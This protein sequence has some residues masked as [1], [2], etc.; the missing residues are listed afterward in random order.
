VAKYGPLA[1]IVVALAAIAALASLAEPRATAGAPTTVA[2]GTVSTPITYQQAE[3]SGEVE[4]IEWMA[5]CDPTTGRI[6]EPSVYA[7]PCLPAAPADNGGATSPG[8]TGETITVAVYVPSPNADFL[9][10]FATLLDEPEAVVTTRDAYV[11]LFE[12]TFE[13]YGRGVELVRFE[14]TGAGDDNT[15][16]QADAVTVA[17]TIR[18][19]AVLGGPDRSSAF[20][21]ELAR[22][23]IVCIAC[24]GV[25]P[26]RFYQDHAPYVWGLQP[27]AEQFLVSLGDFLTQ[28]VV[29]RAASFAGDVDLRE[30]ERVFGVVHIEQSPPVFDQVDERTRECGSARGYEAALTETFLLD[31]G[32]MAQRA[33]TIVAKMKAA[34]VTTI[35]FLGDPIMPIHL[36]RAA[37]EQ[38]YHP[39][40]VI[41]G[42]ALTDTTVFGR[43]YDP[44]QWAH[45]F[46]ISSLG[47]RT[48]REQGDPWRLHEWFHGAPPEAVNTH[49]L[50]YAPLRLLFLGIHMAGADLR[51]QTFAQG[52]FNYPESGGGVTSPQISFGDHGYFEL[53]PGEGE[54]CSSAEPRLDYLATDDVTEIWWDAESTGLDEQGNS[55]T[56]MVRYADGGHRYLPGSMTDEELGAFVEEGSITVVDEVPVDQ[57]PPEYPPPARG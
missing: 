28:R 41:T 33:T 14:G 4:G 48:A 31:F 29:G 43:M 22:R 9:N 18:P 34:G 25:V 55:G 35:I 16:A 36:T 27:T 30:R 47:A 50:I 13:T 17:E 11:E 51:P 23:G 7:P 15:A 10:S 52:L 2:P 39:E 6:R 49:A 3:A 19:F 40:W 53:D 57:R 20:A 45:A 37:T 54:D 32:T 44:E 8:V 38:D 24:S 5:S 56:G 42:T 26:D 46:G 1:V 12:H 21:E